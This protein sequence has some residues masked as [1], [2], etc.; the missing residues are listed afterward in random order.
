[1][2][3]VLATRLIYAGII[4]SGGKSWECPLNVNVPMNMKKV[5]AAVIMMMKISKGRK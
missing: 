3:T 2:K 5:V 4:P 1:M